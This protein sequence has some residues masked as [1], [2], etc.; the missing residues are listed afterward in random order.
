[1]FRGIAAELGLDMAAYDAA[2]TD[3]AT[4][5]RVQADRSDGERL[6]VRSTPSFFIDGEPVVLEAW[7]DL[8]A[9]LEKAV[10][11]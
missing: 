6:G 9:A 5:D 7:G 11:Q 8:E 10:E 3:P 4:L 1:M 2:I